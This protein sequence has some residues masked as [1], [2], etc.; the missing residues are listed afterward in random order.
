MLFFGLS[1][2]FVNSEKTFQNT[3]PR[4]IVFSTAFGSSL[5]LLGPLLGVSWFAMSMAPDPGAIQRATGAATDPNMFSLMILF[6]IP[7]AVHLMVSAATPKKRL[8][9]GLLVVTEMATIILTFSRSAALVLCLVLVFLGLRYRRELKP[10]Y[11][12]LV[13]TGLLIGLIALAMTVPASYWDRHKEALSSQDTSIQARLSYLAV[14]RDEF[15]RNPLLGSGLG[16]FEIAYAN[17]RHAFANPYDL[18]GSAARRSAHNAYIE[19]LV[20]TGLLGLGAFLLIIGLAWRNFRKAAALS[21][22]GGREDL[23]SVILAYQ[24][25]FTAILIHLLTLSRFNHK[26]LWM[27]FALS[28]VALTLAQ[29]TSRI[30]PHECTHPVE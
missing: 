26:Y 5:S 28:Q 30:R 22:A 19:I 4:V 17:S 12:G 16:T 18:S 14:G 15:L 24:L 23:T 29:R 2:I 27:S 8:F 9:W 6:S 7:L 20:G 1:L 11:I 10:R 13:T 3:L 25:G 21:R